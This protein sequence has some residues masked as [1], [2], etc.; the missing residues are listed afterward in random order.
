MQFSKL[1]MALVLFAA[2]AFFS[3]CKKD[4]KSKTELIS[5]NCWVF[6]AITVDPP[7]EENGVLITDVYSQ[8]NQC[9]RDDIFCFKAN[10][11]YSLEEG[12]TKCNDS[13]PQVIETG[14]WTF[15]QTE[16][17]VNFTSDGFTE[18]A[19]IIEIKE[20]SLKFKSLYDEVG[21][22]KYYAIFIAEPI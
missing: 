17:V 9:E 13:H 18:E 4:E 8:Y 6:T 5:A 22:I 12:A 11:I 15:N 16:S 19:E 20:N 21:G 1:P 10:G 3:A 14:T 7:I 2:L